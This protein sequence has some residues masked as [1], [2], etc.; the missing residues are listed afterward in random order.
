MGIIFL[1]STRP[2]DD[3]TLMVAIGPLPWW[4]VN[5]IVH[6]ATHLFLYSVLAVLLAYAVESARRF[7][8]VVVGL[9][10]LYGISDEL[11][12][13]LVPGRGPSGVDVLVDTVGAV[14]GTL[15]WRRY[16]SQT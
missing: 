13:S 5:K 12:Q 1:G 11:H 14:M 6:V 4:V 9:C 10:L 16:A 3:V 7:P 15:V 2:G 8:W